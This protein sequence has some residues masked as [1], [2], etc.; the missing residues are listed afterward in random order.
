MNMYNKSFA[1]LALISTLEQPEE[2]SHDHSQVLQ[3]SVHFGRS[4]IGVSSIKN[5]L[6]DFG[7]NQSERKDKTISCSTS[8]GMCAEQAFDSYQRI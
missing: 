4:Q 3:H 7:G 2:H 5:R 8:S 6:W 1:A